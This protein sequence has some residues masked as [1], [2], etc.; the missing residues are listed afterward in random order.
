MKRVSI[1]KGLTLLFLVITVSFFF[2]NYKVL[3][4]ECIWVYDKGSLLGMETMSVVNRGFIHTIIDDM[5]H[6]FELDES[7]KIYFRLDSR[8]RTLNPV[9]IA[10][11][12]INFKMPY[13]LSVSTDKQSFK[14]LKYFVIPV[15]M[16][17]NYYKVESILRELEGVEFSAKHY[18]I[19]DSFWWYLSFWINDSKIDLAINIKKNGW[20]DGYEITVT[21]NNV[22]EKLN[23]V[24]SGKKEVVYTPEAIKERVNKIVA[25]GLII[26][27]AIL[28]GLW[29]RARSHHRLSIN[30]LQEALY[31]AK[32]RIEMHGETYSRV[33]KISCIGSAVIGLLAGYGTVVTESDI[34]AVFILV[35]GVLIVIALLTIGAWMSNLR[36]LARFKSGEI[37]IG[38]SSIVP[39]IILVIAWFMGL[40]ISASI[41][42]PENLSSTIII[43]IA[44][45]SIFSVLTFIMIKLINPE[46]EIDIVNRKIMEAIEKLKENHSSKKNSLMEDSTKLI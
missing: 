32:K 41:L 1:L 38:S 19:A 29:L 11:G 16:P 10:D 2:I 22:S 17:K 14:P 39:M 36:K 27:T 15:F 31:I 4:N 8:I 34:S 45:G 20:L 33:W 46:K 26:A 12:I 7:E 35:Y 43:T 30:D 5:I 25:I 9:E 37:F 28:G 3:T 44:T 23:L 6:E 18:Y 40:L 21:K 24:W 13:N 42:S